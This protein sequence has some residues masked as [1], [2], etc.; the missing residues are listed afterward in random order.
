M[1]DPDLC[2]PF[3]GFVYTLSH[4]P[5]LFSVV[6]EASMK[7]LSLEVP[8]LHVQPSLKHNYLGPSPF[9]LAESYVTS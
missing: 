1:L 9:D 2:K 5:S 3:V 7:A 6:T 4:F 8:Y